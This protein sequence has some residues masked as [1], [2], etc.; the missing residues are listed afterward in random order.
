MNFQIIS[1]LHGRINRMEINK[2]ADILLFA[3]DSSE[4]LDITFKMLNL[5]TIPVLFIPGNHEF[6]HKDY[7]DTYMR[8]RDFC[9]KS[10]GNII[11]LDNNVVE[12]D[13]Y[14]IIGNTLWSDFLNLDPFLIESSWSNI[15]D[16]RCISTLNQSSEIKDE[17]L[18]LH[19][20]HCQ[21]IKDIMFGNDEI[22][23]NLL[24]PYLEKRISSFNSKNKYD[25]ID[26]NMFTPYHSFIM[27]KKN[28]KWL[29]NILNDKF[30]GKRIV[31]THH[32]PSY[33]PLILGGYIASP[34]E[35]IHSNLE[36]KNALHKIGAYC[37]S[38]ESYLLDNHVD[39]WIHGHFHE[40]FNYRMG[41]SN[42]IC[43]ATGNNKNEDLS[44]R[45]YI[46]N[47]SAEEKRYGLKN[48]LFL[49]NK[50][51]SKILYFLNNTSI[52]QN[53]MTF[54]NN[55][56]NIYFL[57]GC[58]REIEIILNNIQSLPYTEIP[59]SFNNY[60][61]DPF[62]EFKSDNYSNFDSNYI[63]NILND[64]ILNL[65]FMDKEIKEW[66]SIILKRV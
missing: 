9:D 27:N 7:Y 59:K 55:L 58:W 5:S 22:K 28:K 45:N 13:N 29:N 50:S 46:F 33:S 56:S 40:H 20:M 19:E 16:Y 31:M 61:P 4:N 52:S 26:T 30:N 44:L 64:I 57:K 65:E 1:D 14:Q 2:K 12:I 6:Y 10:N 53:I 51:I 54:T 38:M 47:C 49:F 18:T 39:T 23:K 32:A 41:S 24:N 48:Q 8:L 25:Y 63:K 62:S 37:N 36:R 35:L 21:K 3:G 42:V 60:Y 15:N 34:F 17:I 66:I 43:N 11:F